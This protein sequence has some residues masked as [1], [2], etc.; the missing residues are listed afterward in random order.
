VRADN[1]DFK[2][3]LAGFERPGDTGTHSHSVKCHNLD[4]GFFFA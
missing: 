3:V 2:T 1:Q 4:T